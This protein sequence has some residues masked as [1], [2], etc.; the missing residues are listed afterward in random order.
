M[1]FGSAA[2]DI[3]SLLACT[4]TQERTYLIQTGL[5]GIQCNADGPLVCLHLQHLRH[6][7]RNE[8]IVHTIQE[9]FTVH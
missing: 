4:S 2:G 8:R 5:E 1:S 6:G 9:L 3:R 7:L